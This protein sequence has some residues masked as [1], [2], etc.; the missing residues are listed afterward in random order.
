LGLD[1]SRMAKMSGMDIFIEGKSIPLHPELKKLDFE[2]KLL[3]LKAIQSGEEYEVAFS[4]PDDIS[5]PLVTKIGHAAD[6]TGR[7]IMTLE[8]KDKEIS[9]MGYDHLEEL[10][11]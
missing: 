9:R 10:N 2:K 4:S 7:V 5:H 1:L 6:G 3:L 11:K 8:G